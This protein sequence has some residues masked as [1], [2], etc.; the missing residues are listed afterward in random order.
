MALIDDLS[1]ILVEPAGAGFLYVAS[2]GTNEIAVL[3]IHPTTGALTLVRSE[4]LGLPPHAMTVSA[5]GAWL[6]V[7]VAPAN[8]GAAGLTMYQIDSTGG[9]L[10]FI[11]SAT[12]GTNNP[13]DLAID[14]PVGR[15]F[16]LG[17][18]QSSTLFGVTPE[19]AEVV[20]LAI[21]GAGTPS[22]LGSHRTP[23]GARIDRDRG[24]ARCEPVPGTVHVTS[25]MTAATT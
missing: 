4:P 10:T 20:S 19:L 9:R 7:A 18:G 6:S 11:T 2:R 24:W 12:A 16:M 23:T 21:D 22:V 8:T 15:A 25:P 5:D 3:A 1:R 17:V 14:P 13:T